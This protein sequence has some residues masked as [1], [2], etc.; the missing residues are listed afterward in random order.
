MVEWP[1][2]YQGPQGGAE[3][4]SRFNKHFLP[5]SLSS[6]WLVQQRSP[7]FGAIF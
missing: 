4:G 5:Y 1:L 2:P 7:W 3:V 6:I